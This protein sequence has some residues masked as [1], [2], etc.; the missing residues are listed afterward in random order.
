MLREM[1]GTPWIS[2]YSGSQVTQVTTLYSGPLSTTTYI[3]FCLLTTLLSSNLL[4]KNA[5]FLLPHNGPATIS[6][7]HYVPSLMMHDAICQSGPTK[8]GHATSMQKTNCYCLHPNV[9]SAAYVA[10]PAKGVPPRAT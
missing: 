10:S 2:Q 5:F 4:L 3:P 9:G 8:I 1:H 6:T 7:L